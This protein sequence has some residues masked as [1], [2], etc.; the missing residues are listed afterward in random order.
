MPRTGMDRQVQN[1][2]HLVILEILNSSIHDNYYITGNLCI[3]LL[4]FG[5]RH[6]EWW[7]PKSALT[8]SRRSP[9]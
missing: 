8:F 7:C 1:D 4:S 9:L 6:F 3:T 5:A 2:S